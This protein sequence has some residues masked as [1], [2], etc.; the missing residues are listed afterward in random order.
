MRHFL[1]AILAPIAALQTSHADPS[2]PERA[3]DALERSTAFMR[4]ISAGGGYLW[5]Y[6]PDLKARAG[7]TKAS[8]TQVWIQP[9]GT[10]SMGMA[11]L[12]IYHATKDALYL[13]AAKAAAEGLA[14]GQLESGGWDYLIDFDPEKMLLSYLRN[15]VGKL[16]PAQIAKRRNTTTYDDDT[17]QSALR[18]LLAVVD[19]DKGKGD[20]RDGRI[21]EALDYGLKKMIEAQYPNGAWPQRW[22]GKAHPIEEF[23]VMKARFPRSYPRE[24]PKVN[25]FGHY[26]LNDN[27]LHDC[28]GVMLDAFHRTGNAEY[29]EAAKKGGDFII[30]AQMPQPQPVW[31][32]QYNAQME[33]AWARAFEPPAVTGNESVGAIRMLMELHVETGDEKFLKPIPDAIAWFKRSKLESGLWARYY[34]LET[35]KQIFGDRDGKIYFRLADLSEERQH[36]YSW[37]GDYGATNMMSYY[38]KIRSKARES[39]LA[40]RAKKTAPRKPDTEAAKALEPRVREI[41]NALDKQGRWVTR[42]HIQKR[43]WEFNDRIETEVFIKNTA[44]LAAYL[45]AIR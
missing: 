5:K 36:G 15:D 28:I 29:L 18:F 44:T 43:N 11:F 2:L 10:P 23:P 25:Y 8:E 17:T 40:E 34:E 9:P 13:D 14:A 42:G 22:A 19:T 45:E 35:N 38:D 31:A 7:E 30:L 20:A 24:Y 21:R 1:F 26:T 39:L 33:P 3:R 16:S 27:T 32:Q 37:S 4:S 12:R 41:I 6:S